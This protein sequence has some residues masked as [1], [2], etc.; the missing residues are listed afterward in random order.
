[1]HTIERCVDEL[2]E[3]MHVAAADDAV[4]DEYRANVL[5]KARE[6]VNADLSVLLPE[7][8]R[9][10][11][12]ALVEV[13]AEPESI[14]EFFLEHIPTYHEALQHSLDGF[15]QSYL[16]QRS[17]EA[18]RA[19]RV[20][21]HRNAGLEAQARY[22]RRKGEMVELAGDDGTFHAWKI[23]DVVH[24]ADRADVLFHGERGSIMTLGAVEAERREADVGR[25]RGG[26]TATSIHTL[27]IE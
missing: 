23:G 7:A 4:M 21:D 10:D 14:Q 24:G 25:T 1:M 15:V 18:R 17:A 8:C 26:A 22:A 16:Q 2:L 19:D 5:Q 20:H 11:F 3:R 12:Y 27:T 9:G 13:H 6:H